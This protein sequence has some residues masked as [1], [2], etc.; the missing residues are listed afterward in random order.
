MPRRDVWA[1]QSL[2]G[3]REEQVYLDGSVWELAVL[4]AG[5]VGKV[6]VGQKMDHLAAGSLP[7]TAYQ[8]P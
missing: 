2:M 3:G 7:P 1:K 5:E 8:L 6:C 4:L